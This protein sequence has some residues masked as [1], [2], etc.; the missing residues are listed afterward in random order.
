MRAVRF[1]V[2]GAP[3]RHSSRIVF[4]ERR[5]RQADQK[6][7]LPSPSGVRV[8]GN[9]A[10]R[11]SWGYCRPPIIHLEW[12]QSWREIGEDADEA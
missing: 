7:R 6:R 10:E 8:Q 9:I 1:V 4:S 2:E 12:A 5:K 11:W 3:L